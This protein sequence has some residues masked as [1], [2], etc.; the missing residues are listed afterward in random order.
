M[1]PRKHQITNTL[2]TEPV[3][4]QKI[5]LSTAEKKHGTTP[6]DEC[7]NEGS[8]WVKKTKE[9]RMMEK[10]DFAVRWRLGGMKN[11]NERMSRWHGASGDG[12]K[13]ECGLIVP[14]IAHG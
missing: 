8:E 5:S 7:E 9:E 14:V 4:A 1:M 12:I 2:K 11:F 10:Q 3:E 6:S 13:T